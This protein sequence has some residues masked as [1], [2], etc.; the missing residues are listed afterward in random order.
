MIQLLALLF[1]VVFLSVFI[2]SL[3]GKRLW[4]LKRNYAFLYIDWVFVPFNFLIAYSVVFSWKIF[5]ISLIVTAVPTIILH[6]RWNKLNNVPKEIKYFVSENGV[7][8]EGKIHFVFMTLQAA[9]VLTVI[10]SRA[11][12]NYYLLMMLCLLIYFI[13]YLLTVIFVRHIRL[14]SKPETPYM[15]TGLL[16]VLIRTI[17]YFVFRI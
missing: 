14:R 15:L 4:F 13:S 9:I 2:I 11:T 17:V 7:S 10:F 12:S 6:N 8:L 3:R 1:P 16:L 5:V